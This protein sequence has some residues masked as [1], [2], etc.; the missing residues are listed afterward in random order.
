ML[1]D[2]L[3]LIFSNIYSQIFMFLSNRDA[4]SLWVFEREKQDLFRFIFS[5]KTKSCTQTITYETRVSKLVRTVYVLRA[6]QT[7]GAQPNV[8]LSDSEGWS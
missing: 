7:S 3:N 2:F 1:A 5:P 4:R 8:S 6:F